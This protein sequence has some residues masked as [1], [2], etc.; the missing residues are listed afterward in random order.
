MNKVEIDILIG[1]LKSLISLAETLDP[2][3]A[4]NKFII[5]VNNA[6][7]ALQALGL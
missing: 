6:I 1:V 4:Q 3:V 2:N 7:A 5:E